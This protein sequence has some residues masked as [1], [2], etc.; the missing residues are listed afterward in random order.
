MDPRVPMIVDAIAELYGLPPGAL[1]RRPRTPKEA[2]AGDVGMY[3]ARLLGLDWPQIAEAFGRSRQ[4]AADR[5][6]GLEAKIGTN[7]FL[8]WHLAQLRGALDELTG[9]LV[10]ERI[11][12]LAGRAPVENS[13]RNP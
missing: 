10:L 6:R 13:R 8:E 9:R 11:H 7:K 3:Q 2:F 4:T 5:V 12:A 1:T